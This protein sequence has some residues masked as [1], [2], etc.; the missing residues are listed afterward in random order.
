MT[1]TTLYKQHMDSKLI[2]PSETVNSHTGRVN[3]LY[4]LT[5]R[6]S[7]LPLNQVRRFYCERYILKEIHCFLVMLLDYATHF[8]FEHDLLCVTSTELYFKNCWGYV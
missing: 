3:A 4:F 5:T 2:G 6:W 1:V 8:C 7:P